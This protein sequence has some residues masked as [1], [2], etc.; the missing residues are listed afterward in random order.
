MQ[1]EVRTYVITQKVHWVIDNNLCK[2]ICHDPVYAQWLE[3]K[4]IREAKEMEK[5]PE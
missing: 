5:K 3:D 2:H 1:V 4:F